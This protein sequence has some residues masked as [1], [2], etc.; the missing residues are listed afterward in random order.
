M[1]LINLSGVLAVCLLFINWYLRIISILFLNGCVLWN[2]YRGCIVRKRCWIIYC[3]IGCN[4]LG[5]CA[6]VDCNTCGILIRNKRLAARAIL[7]CSTILLACLCLIIILTGI[8]LIC[9]F[10]IQIII[11]IQIFAYVLLKLAAWITI[12]LLNKNTQ[13]G[14]LLV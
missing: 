1:I 10:A 5:S 13:N 3:C 2:V 14:R 9:I 7:I 11:N 6:G 8:Y 4:I 12:I